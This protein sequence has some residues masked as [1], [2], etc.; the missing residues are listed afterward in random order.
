V[1]RLLDDSSYTAAAQRLREQ[2]R[3]EAGSGAALAELEGLATMSSRGS[4]IRRS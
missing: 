2:L 3:A 4:A 1:Q